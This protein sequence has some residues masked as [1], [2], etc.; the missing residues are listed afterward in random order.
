MPHGAVDDQH[1][2][3]RPGNLVDEVQQLQYKWLHK[4]NVVMPGYLH[5]LALLHGMNMV[6][7]LVDAYH[8]LCSSERWGRRGTGR[9][10][11]L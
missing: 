9:K 6:A 1:A 4:V 2:Q 10:A 3:D 5:C 8:C 7:L 11:T